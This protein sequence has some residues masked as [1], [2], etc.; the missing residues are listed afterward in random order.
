MGESQ[1]TPNLLQFGR[2]LNPL[3]TPSNAIMTEMS[4]DQMWIQRKKILAQFWTKWQTDYLS[5][6]SIATKWLKDE[7]TVIKPGDV[8]ILKPETLEKG[9]WRLARIMGVH[10]NL[11]GVITT[12]SVKL[13]GG[14]VFTRTL[15]QIALLESAI[16]ESKPTEAVIEEITEPNSSQDREVRTGEEFDES[17]PSPLDAKA[18]DRSRPNLGPCPGM[19]EPSSSCIPPGDT[20]A[21][22]VAPEPQAQA[23]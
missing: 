17:L 3:R 4:C 10:K 2:M 23:A 19:G 20:D 15:R 22:A 21:A 12:A 16:S 9:Q 8:V 1:I 14:T 6:L 5:T 13:P 7:Q 11:D 18:V